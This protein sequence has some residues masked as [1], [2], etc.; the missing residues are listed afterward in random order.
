MREEQV[1]AKAQELK[2]KKPNE[3]CYYNSNISWGESFGILVEFTYRENE[4]V[5]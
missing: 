2:Y 4:N 3:D 5:T 1:K